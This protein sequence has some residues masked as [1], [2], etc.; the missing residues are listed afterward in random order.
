M[1]MNQVLWTLGVC[2]VGEDLWFTSAEFDGLFRADMKTGRVTFV[3]RIGVW[4]KQQKFG[5]SCIVNVDNSL[6]LCPFYAD[7]IC[8]YDLHNHKVQCFPLEL[9][10]TPCVNRAAHFH[11]KI[12]MFCD[13]LR[14]ILVFDVKTGEISYIYESPDTKYNFHNACDIA[15]RKEFFYFA[16]GSKVI[17]TDACFQMISEYDVSKY[18][19]GEEIATVALYE[20]TFWM[21]CGKTK[22]LS[23]NRKNNEVCS[24]KIPELGSAYRSIINK[25]YLYVLYP[26]TNYILIVNLENM[27]VAKIHRKQFG[28]QDGE[29]RVFLPFL[30]KGDNG[31]FAY[32]Y[33]DSGIHHIKPDGEAECV[34]LY[35]EHLHE[36]L[37]EYQRYEFGTKDFL[38]YENGNYLDSLGFFLDCIGVRHAE[39]E[40]EYSG[41]GEAIYKKIKENMDNQDDTI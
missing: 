1:I 6:F 38:S 22:L 18:S 37:M 2:L 23:W 40:S 28:S 11:G 16:R 35:M 39:G 30:R 27:D 19:E 3:S 5:F 4:D 25:H 36:F 8:R 26:D 34:P 32:S 12:Y 31:I 20:E 14:L 13:E 29:R 21:I 7:C 24:Y 15:C 10:T 41:S 9:E 17:E 33:I